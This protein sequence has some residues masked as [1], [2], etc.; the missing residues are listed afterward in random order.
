MGREQ[1]WEKREE[2][3]E[4]RVFGVEELGAVIHCEAVPKRRGPD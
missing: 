3:V 1:I 2:R 4:K